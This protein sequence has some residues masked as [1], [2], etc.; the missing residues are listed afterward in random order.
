MGL[1]NIS[2]RK[3]TDYLSVLSDG[4]PAYLS[5]GHQARGF[6]HFIVRRYRHDIP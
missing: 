2:E 6:P 4:Q 1:G 5:E 3:H